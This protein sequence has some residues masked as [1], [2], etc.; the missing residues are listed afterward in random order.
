MPFYL[1]KVKGGWKVANETDPTIEYSEKPLTKAKAK[2]QF[3]ALILSEHEKTHGVQGGVMSLMSLARAAYNL[4]PVRKKYSSATTNFLNQSGNFPI[5]N[6]TIYRKPLTSFVGTALNVASLGAWQR[7]V[8]KNGM[9]KV[10]HLYM[11]ATVQTNTQQLSVLIEKNE[12][13]NIK[14]ATANDMQQTEGTY[15]KVEQIPQ[16]LTVNVMLQRT[17]DKMGNDRYWTYN[18][19]TNNCQ[20][21]IKYLLDSS[22]LLTP[23][24][25]NFVQQPIENIANS[26]SAPVKSIANFT[27]GI[28][29]RIRT[30]TGRG[31]MLY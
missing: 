28:A 16:G 29:S 24:L 17:K 11:I 8:K 14:V 4:V 7:A 9:D 5:V 1:K 15:M 13:I 20:T 3:Y 25:L 30:I 6:I 27:T 22:G 19:Q 12:I 26:L 2:K 18:F 10:F 23:Q 21:F 31:M